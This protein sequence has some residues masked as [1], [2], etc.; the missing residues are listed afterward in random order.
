MLGQMVAQIEAGEFTAMPTSDDNG[1]YMMLIGKRRSH[2]I[3]SDD[4]CPIV[5]REPYAIGSGSDFAMGAM[6]AGKS[7][8]D[9]VKIAAKLDC[10][11]GGPIKVLSLD[12]LRA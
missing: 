4:M 6:L 10:Y 2:L 5:I 1:A 9:A 12:K 11:T 3:S 7:A 8:K